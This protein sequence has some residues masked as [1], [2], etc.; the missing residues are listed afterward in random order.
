MINEDAIRII[1]T[2]VIFR[3]DTEKSAL[4]LNSSDVIVA[5]CAGAF[6]YN[7]QTRFWE[8]LVRGPHRVP[9][10]LESPIDGI[11][12]GILTT[13]DPNIGGARCGPRTRS[14]RTRSVRCIRTQ[15]LNQQQ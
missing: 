8:P 10:M 13:G 3:G 11:P 5:G 4:M 7:D 1:A 2:V 9:Q 12:T 6:V 15:Q 14:Y